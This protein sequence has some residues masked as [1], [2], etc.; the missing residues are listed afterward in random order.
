MTYFERTMVRHG[1]PRHIIL[2]IVGFTWAIYFLWR[3]DWIW[4]SAAVL[5][6]VA[7][8]A[9][10]TPRNREESLAQTTLGKIMLLHLH[11]ANVMLQLTGFALLLYGVWVHSSILIL[12][13]GSLILAGHMW[14]WQK[15]SGA[16]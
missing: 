14:G 16:L 12:A 9:I 6:S 8:G 7:L 4:A 10:L 5:I 13:A 2:R 11:P 1:H 3:H 15:V